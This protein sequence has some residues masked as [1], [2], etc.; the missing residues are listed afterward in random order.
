[1]DRTVGP[2]GPNKLTEWTEQ[3]PSVTV[4]HLTPFQCVQSL[5]IVPGNASPLSL[6]EGEAHCW[7]KIVLESKQEV[8]C[9]HAWWQNQRASFWNCYACLFFGHCPL[10]VNV[11]AF[12]SV[13]KDWTWWCILKSPT[14]P[15]GL[16]YCQPHRAKIQVRHT[17]DSRC[18]NSHQILTFSNEPSL[19]RQHCWL[20]Q[21]AVWCRCMLQ[22]PIIVL[23]AHFRT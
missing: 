14:N 22:G 7:L 23:H 12:V 21:H 17:W 8:C 10:S 11:H 13:S 19:H 20:R 16:F 3:I 1:M 4:C 18:Y 5:C 6:C 15:I 9:G 2:N